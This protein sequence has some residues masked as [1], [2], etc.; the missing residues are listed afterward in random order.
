MVL[1]RP[2][3]ADSLVCSCA[4]SAVL[5]VAVV[6][7]S[8]Q[9]CVPAI[10]NGGWRDVRPVGDVPYANAQEHAGRK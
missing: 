8:D 2:G 7:G 10:Q 6:H 5:K 4:S 9:Q 1:V 3:L